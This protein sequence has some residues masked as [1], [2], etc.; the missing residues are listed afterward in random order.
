LVLRWILEVTLTLV[1]HA[2]AIGQNKSAVHVLRAAL[3]VLIGVQEDSILVSD[4][5]KLCYEVERPLP[6]TIKIL[7]SR[8]AHLRL[9]YANT[10]A[11]VMPELNALL[12][13]PLHQDRLHNFK[14]FNRF[15]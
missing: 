11:S 3:I 14:A 8:N 10:I 6:R 12:L 2:F 13:Q 7:V 4:F 1:R 5:K 15:V 9:C